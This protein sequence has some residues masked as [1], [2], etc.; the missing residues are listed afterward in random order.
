MKKI[1]LDIY[2]ADAGEKE[3]L[4]GAVKT[5]KKYSFYLYYT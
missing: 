1:I 2:G 3:I 4:L 5:L